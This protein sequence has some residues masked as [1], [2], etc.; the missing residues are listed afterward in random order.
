MAHHQQGNEGIGLLVLQHQH[1]PFG[2]TRLRAEVIGERRL[3]F[4]ADLLERSPETARVEEALFKQR[5]LGLEEELRTM[6]VAVNLAQKELRL[7]EQLYANGDAS[8]SELLRV[9]RGLNEA[10]ARVRRSGRPCS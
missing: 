6:R 5:Q 1:L 9:Q 10:E 7:V 8:G 4:Q 3:T 2:A